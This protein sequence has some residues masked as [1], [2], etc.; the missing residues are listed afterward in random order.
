MSEVRF[1]IGEVI[2]GYDDTYTNPDKKNKKEK[3]KPY[4]IRVKIIDITTSK[5]RNIRTAIPY[6]INNVQVPVKGEQ[7]LIIR[8]FKSNS[9]HDDFSS[10]W[11]YISSFSSN[12][13]SNIN[14][15]VSISE[16][17]L[18]EQHVELKRKRY[19]EITEKNISLLQLYPGD[20]V[21]SGRFG[22]TIRLGST[23]KFNNNV[24][25]S[26]LLGDTETQGDPVIILSNTK[27]HNDDKRFINENIKSD[28]SSLYLTSTQK[29]SNLILNNKLN[30]GTS[31]SDY[32]GSQFIGVA[33]R[34][35][36]KAK[37]DIIALDSK[38]AIEINSPKIRFGTSNNKEAMLYGG[39]VKEILEKLVDMVSV[40]FAGESGEACTAIYDQEFGPLFKQLENEHIMFDKHPE[41]R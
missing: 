16:Q 23:T 12:S 27:E 29:L 10:Q 25:Q 41:R 24:I 14:S 9:K 30:I 5:D 1:E 17:K 7:V 11:Y 20:R 8:G 35:I 40:G 28:Y 4:S 37:T 31:E 15:L 6:D 34:V 13:S 22:N 19:K 36:L 2:T 21:L 3:I 33:D 32:N 39:V 26:R 18:T 38:K